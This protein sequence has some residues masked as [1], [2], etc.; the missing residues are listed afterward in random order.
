M[1]IE[2]LL[3]A[4]T[5]LFCSLALSQQAGTPPAS[6]APPAQNEAPRFVQTAVVEL[7]SFEVSVTDAHG[8]VHGLTA[9]DF[10]VLHDGKPVELSNFSS[11]SRAG[12][13]RTPAM[14]AESS[15]PDAPSAEAPAAG[16]RPGLSLNFYVDNANL[17]TQGRG[18]ILDAAIEFVRTRVAPRDRVAVTTNVGGPKIVQGLTED[19]ELAVSALRRLRDEP[20]TWSITSVERMR[21]TASMRMT[22]QILRQVSATG[23]PGASAQ[24]TAIAQGALDEVRTFE[25]TERVATRDATRGLRAIVTAMSAMPGRKV[26]VYLSDGLAG[27]PGQA[28]YRAF[29][30]SFRE[31]SAARSQLNDARM[32]M[33]G[34]GSEQKVFDEVVVSAAAAGV[35]LYTIDARG[36]VAPGDAESSG[37]PS[38]TWSQDVR[39][40]QEPLQKIAAETGGSAFFNGG[41]FRAGLDRF[42]RELDSYY[43][44]GYPLPHGGRNPVHT[45][46]VELVNR[47]GCRLDYRQRFVEKSLPALVEDRVLAALSFGPAENLLGIAASVGAAKKGASKTRELPVRILVP[48]G[49]LALLP[50]GEEMVGQVTAYYVTRGSD[51]KQ[52]ALLKADHRVAVPRGEYESARGRSWPITATLVVKPGSYRISVAVREQLTG[53]AGYATLEVPDDSGSVGSGAPVR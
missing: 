29:E 20:G 11:Y 3:L 12:E 44:L 40:Y 7:V 25:Q 23:R 32:A 10:R 39:N 42:S 16:E 47:K 8:P 41:D 1:R 48:I 51:G 28:G 36:L 27:T 38:A 18:R 53:T 4:G 34:E 26:L 31:F 50:V 45:V 2:G 46:D 49:K 24:A 5:T 6:G 52:S 19:R 22:A 14:T 33:T 21:V 30:E 13:S 15:K 37:A 9:S 43:L 35:T 17:S